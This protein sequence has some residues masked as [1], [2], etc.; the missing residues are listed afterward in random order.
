LV[1]KND[2]AKRAIAETRQYLDDADDLMQTE[3]TVVD[4]FNARI[5]RYP[6]HLGRTVLWAGASI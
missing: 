6:N 1:N 4:F 3:Q 5:E 2:D